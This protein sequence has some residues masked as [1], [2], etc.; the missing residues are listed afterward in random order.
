[1]QLDRET[2]EKFAEG[3]RVLKEAF[4]EYVRTLTEA[5]EIYETK[6][7]LLHGTNS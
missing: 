6:S 5:N 2:Y 7:R 1:M 4:V 3:E